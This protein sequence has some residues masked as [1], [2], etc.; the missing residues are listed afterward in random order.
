MKETSMSIRFLPTLLTAAL[1]FVSA[2]NSQETRTPEVT[3]SASVVKARAVFSEAIASPDLPGLSVAIADESGLLWAEGFGFADLENDVPMTD[4]H[5]MR[6]GSV[7]KVLTAAAL[8]RQVEAGQLDLD[9]DVRTWV[10]EW[11]ES[12]APVTLRQLTAHTAGVRHYKGSGEVL[13]NERYDSSVAALDMFKDDPLKFEPGSQFSYSTFAWTLITAAM[14]GADGAR[15]FDAIMRQEVFDPLAMENTHLDDQF[16][17]VKGRPRPYV[18][19]EGALINAPQTDHSYKWAGGGIIAT[20]SDVVRFATA[21]LSEGYLKGETLKEMMTKAELTSGQEGPVG[22]GWFV[23]FGG[24]A[25]R[26]GDNTEISRILS[27]HGN[28]VLH[29]G[30]SVGGIT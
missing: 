1:T 12:H 15:D 24:R 13:S 23:G 10:P 3:E 22:I 8:M 11:P 27:E 25:D 2:C 6:I 7:A 19:Y 18:L 30:G 20:P 5:T 9:T 26:Y 29:G 16:A 28:V 4:L 17:I 21:Q 14:E